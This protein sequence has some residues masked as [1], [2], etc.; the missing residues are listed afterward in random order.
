M[1][2]P[3]FGSLGAGRDAFDEMGALP[4]L[5]DGLDDE[6]DELSEVLA[7]FFDSSFLVSGEIQVLGGEL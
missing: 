5:L 1:T 4:D 2:I 6:G 3:K 7:A